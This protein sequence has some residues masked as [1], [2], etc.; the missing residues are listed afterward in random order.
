MDAAGRVGSGPVDQWTLDIKVAMLPRIS[1][2]PHLCISASLHLRISESLHLH[3]VIMMHGI[4]GKAA[5]PLGRAVT[6]ACLIPWSKKRYYSLPLPHLGV[7]TQGRYPVDWH[8]FFVTGGLK[9]MFRLIFCFFSPFL[10]FS[11]WILPFFVPDLINA[12]YVHGCKEV[13]WNASYSSIRMQHFCTRSMFYKT[14]KGG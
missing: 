12:K 6:A 8:G 4:G 3:S 11:S 14:V 10:F 1:A 9:P 5:G 2:S 13:Q 7:N